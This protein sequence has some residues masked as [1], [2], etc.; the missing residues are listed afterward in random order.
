MAQVRVDVAEKCLAIPQ[1]FFFT[2]KVPLSDV[3]KELKIDSSSGKHIYTLKL[4]GNFGE[5]DVTFNDYEG[6]ADFVYSF[7]KAMMT[8]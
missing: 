2:K 6:Y 5:Q 1:W 3:H 7:E 8:S 4:T